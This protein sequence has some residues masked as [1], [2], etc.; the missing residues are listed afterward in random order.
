MLW[1]SAPLEIMTR[2]NAPITAT[3]ALAVLYLSPAALLA[4][5]QAHHRVPKTAAATST[6]TK[7]RTHKPADAQTAD[8]APATRKKHTTKRRKRRPQQEE[9][10]DPPIINRAA[11]ATASGRRSTLAADSAP[12][13]ATSADF[14]RAAGQSEPEDAKPIVAMS[15]AADDDA[16]PAPTQNPASPS[17]AK[18]TS[19]VSVARSSMTER[20]QLESVEEAAATPVILPPLYN[21]RGRLIMPAPLKGSREILL[22][23]N[24]VADRDGLDRIRDDNDLLD[25]REKNL[26]VA[27]PDS[28]S[29]QVDE[30]LPGNRRYCRPWTAQ[31]L[32]TM[33]R[34]H[35]ARFH[36]PLQVN[37]AVR[38]VEFQQRLLHTNG[39]AAPAE[40]DTASPHLTGQAVDVAKHGLSLTE[41]AW[42]RGYL[43][44]LV[45]QGKVDVEEEFQ[46]SCFHISVYKKYLPSTAAPNRSIA[47]THSNGTAALAAAIR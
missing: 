10:S 45:Q 18:P 39:N 15:A 11:R 4:T 9:T 20:P 31:F 5:P 44:P 14:L 37:S 33:A 34:A 29:L 43:L 23:Q 2:L 47:A 26:L 21:K 6:T 8:P 22:R 35:Y 36:T 25:M 17:A 12:R 28:G 19:V 38:T 41:I 16:R 46:Q 13:K 32:A 40:G 42:M 1:R 30:R 27:I 24:Q 7:K 3:L